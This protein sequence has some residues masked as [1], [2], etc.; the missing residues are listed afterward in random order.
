MSSTLSPIR[1]GVLFDIVLDGGEAL[2]QEA[3][4]LGLSEVEGA[5]RLDRKVEWVVRQ[6]A[7][8]P[9]GTERELQRGFAELDEQG[10]LLIVG[11]SISDNAL[12]AQ[13]LADQ[14]GLPSINFSGGAITRSHWMF[15]YQIGSLEEEPGLLVRRLATRGVRRA[16]VI[17][18]AS[19]VGRNYFEAFELAREMRGLE[20]S[21]SAAVSPVAEDLRSTVEQLRSTEPGALVYLGLGLA[22]R[23]VDIA[24]RDLGWEI[25]VLA[26]SALMWGYLRSEWANA[27]AGWEYLDSISD[28]NPVRQALEARS[29]AAAA[30]PLNCGA[31]DMGR[32]VGEAIARSQHLTRAG[33]RAGLERI[34]QIDAASGAPGTT[35]SF[36]NYD[37]GALHGTFLV[38]RTW[39]DGRSVQVRD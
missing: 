28:D 37:H 2:F 9:A 15:H 35:L 26:N 16:A 21:G 25:P 6:A 23:P 32:L 24:L 33:L 11:P 4:A 12:I 1:I 10:V 39:R 34:N 13:P 7:G 22:A 36:A 3:L 17:Y 20:M 18:D 30:T 27:F 5:G 38:L 14:A 19:A 29:P 8:L 31:Y